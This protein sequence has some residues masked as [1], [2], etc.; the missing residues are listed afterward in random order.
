MAMAVA[1]TKNTIKTESLGFMAE[2]TTPTTVRPMAEI[3]IALVKL[4]LCGS[5]WI[6]AA[7]THPISS[8]HIRAIGAL[9]AASDISVNGGAMTKR[10]MSER[11]VPMMAVMRT[12][13]RV[14]ARIT[15]IGH[16]T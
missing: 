4:L 13:A 9:Y 8:S 7:S 5:R 3:A 15:M 6:Q 12:R 11:T 16:T 10:M 14:A 1:T 2:A